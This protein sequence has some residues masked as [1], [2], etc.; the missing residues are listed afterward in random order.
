MI[1]FIFSGKFKL[2]MQA[3]AFAPGHITGFFK[4]EVGPKDPEHKGSI[5]AGFCI[6]EG[7]TTKVKITSS[8]RPEFKITVSGYKSDNTQVS[9]FV[10]R[11]FF[12]IVKENYF[13]DIEHKT[14]IPVGYGL[15]SSGAVALSLAFALNKALGTNLSRTKIGQ[16]AHNAEIHCKTGLGT[17][18]SSYHGGFEIRTKHGAPGIGSLQKIHT[19]YSAIVICFSPISTK[20]FIKS[21]LS[22]IN[23]LGGKM[24]TRLLESRDQME[25]L[26][27]SLEFAKYVH[28][29]TPKMQQV[30]DDLAHHGF[31]SGVAMFGETIFTLVPKSKES[32]VVRILEKYN[33][34]VIKTEIDKSGARVS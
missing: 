32:Q 18:L 10:V 15:G 9:E 11:E 13:L 12:K 33:A 21:E 25:F 24:V 6:K 34:M 5:G 31:K 26:D 1:I 30:I 16:I 20:Q 27:M 17:V 3:V 7:V 28:V 4:A 22:K 29:I 2:N 23:G 14:T 8:D 19:D